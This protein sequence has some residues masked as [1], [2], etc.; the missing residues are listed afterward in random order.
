MIKNRLGGTL[1]KLT[2]NYRRI[3]WMRAPAVSSDPLCAELTLPEEPASLLTCAQ[4][5]AFFRVFIDEQ[6]AGFIAARP[7]HYRAWTGWNIVEE[8]LHPTFRRKGYAAA[9]QQAFIK[10][11]APALG[12]AVFGTINARNTPSLKTALRV[13]RQVAKCGTFVFP[14]IF[15]E[16]RLSDWRSPLNA[17]R[18]GRQ[19]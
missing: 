5:N 11:L 3:S 10:K 13:G 1:C 17:G 6:L 12:T 19:V 16:P 8:L 2:P 18:L 4:K 9:M 15:V 14:L 7:E